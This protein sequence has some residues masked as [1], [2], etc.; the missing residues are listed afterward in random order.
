MKIFLLLLLCINL[1]FSNELASID[2]VKGKVKVLK[3]N[4]IRTSKVKVA[5]KL[6]KNDLLITFKNSMATIRLTDNSLITL[7]E[8]TKLRIEDIQKIKQEKGQA[9]FNIETQGSKSLKISTSFATIGVKGTKFIINNT[10]TQSVALKSGLVSVEAVKGEFE[11]HK[12]KG[13]K[14]SDYAVYKMAHQYEYKQYKTKLEEE[15]IEFRKQFDLKPNNFVIFKGNVVKE[16]T[17]NKNLKKEFT[18]FENFQK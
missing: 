18:R 15:F 3:N 12:K 4:A 10:T 5:Q 8:N 17:L 6:Y 2:V 1:S 14:L 11:L 16:N 13:K 7:D 9:F